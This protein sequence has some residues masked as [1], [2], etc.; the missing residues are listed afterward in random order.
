MLF[1]ILP[2]F[3]ITKWNGETGENWNNQPTQFVKNFNGA[4]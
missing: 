3:A 2:K 1:K 4:T